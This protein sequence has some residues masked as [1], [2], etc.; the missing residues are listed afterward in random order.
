MRKEQ[1][2][3]LFLRME[4]QRDGMALG[5]GKAV[6]EHPAGE[7]C[8]SSLVE[9]ESDSSSGLQPGDVV[10][11]GSALELPQTSADL[12]SESPPAILACAFLPGCCLSCWDFCAWECWCRAN[13][14]PQS[15]PHP[16]FSLHGS[17]WEE[18]S[19]CARTCRDFVP[20]LLF[21]LGLIEGSFY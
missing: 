19:I 16:C 6:G 11:A 7:C 9:R 8:K 13:Q 14:S 4:S 1:E 12:P 2:K 21:P 18:I 15:L 20:G 10:S 17:S 3:L 5:V